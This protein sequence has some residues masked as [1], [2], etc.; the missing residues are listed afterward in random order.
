MN[1][2]ICQPPKPE[3]P[4]KRQPVDNEFLP[5]ALEIL[6]MPP[7]PTRTASFWFIC[8]LCLATIARSYFGTFGIVS[9]TQGKTQPTGR[10]KIIQALEL[11]K[12][13]KV[14]VAN[15]SN[16]RAGDVLVELDAMELKSD[17]DA[18]ASSLESYQGE[19]VRRDAVLAEV[20]AWQKDGIW[21]CNRLIPEASLSF[22]GGTPARIRK[23]EQQIYNA[24]LSQ[25][26]RLSKPSRLSGSNSKLPSID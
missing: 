14:P 25:I 24:D 4:I 12:T 10:V 26:I 11:G 21:N 17:K 16:V 13:R 9:T 6:E 7:S 2:A 3:K 5:V 22:A 15:G 20:A 19:I 8:I 1:V 23:R 18:A